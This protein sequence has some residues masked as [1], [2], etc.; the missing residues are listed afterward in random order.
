VLLVVHD[1]AL[2]AAVA[3][4]AVIVSAGRTIASG[5]PAAILSPERLA[6]TWDADARLSEREG[7]TALH[8]AWTKPSAAD[9]AAS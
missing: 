9:R 2:A 7:R 1:L 6:E 8:V 5:R 3:D 4:A